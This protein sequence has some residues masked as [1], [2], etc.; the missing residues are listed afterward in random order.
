MILCKDFSLNGNLTVTHSNHCVVYC[1]PIAENSSTTFL[2]YINV[3]LCNFL[4]KFSGGTMIVI[5]QFKY[6][7]G[8]I[9][10]TPSPSMWL[11]E[12][13]TKTYNDCY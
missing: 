5:N 2:K 11:L 8:F 6:Q 7:P 1:Y 3:L 4:Y 13:Y 10:D 12:Q 9:Y